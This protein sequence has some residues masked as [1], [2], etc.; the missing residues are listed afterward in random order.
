MEFSPKRFFSLMKRDFLLN[1]K[2]LLLLAI[3]LASVTAMIMFVSTEEYC[4]S[5]SHIDLTDIFDFVLFLGGIVFSVSIFI[6]FRNESHRTMYLNLPSSNFEKWLSKWIISLPLFILIATCIVLISYSAMSAMITNIWEECKFVS[7]KN[8]LLARG[9]SKFKFYL[10]FQ[11]IAFLLGVV[12]N[13]HA[14]LKAIPIGFILVFLFFYFQN[15]FVTSML[16]T[17]YVTPE[18]FDYY[19]G[20]LINSLVYITPIIWLASYFKLKEKEI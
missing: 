8:T 19:N 7:L 9:V 20:M 6:E 17:S 4:S 14:L 15:K 3:A 1:R 5:P 18:D 12:F 16:T 10:F 2:S 13:K 11:S